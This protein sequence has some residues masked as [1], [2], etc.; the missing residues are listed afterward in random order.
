MI[1]VS[2]AIIIEKGRVLA[3]RR[4]VTMPHPLKWEFP[5]GKL[6]QGES[7]QESIVREIAEEL[8][9]KVI[10]ERLLDPVHHHYELQSVKLI[11]LVCRIGKGEISLAEHQE[12]RWIAPDKLDEMDWLDADLEVVEMVKRQFAL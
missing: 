1:E 4:S 5:G 11:P 10:P 6:K 8:G 3:T 7:P 12:Y 9:I 2:C